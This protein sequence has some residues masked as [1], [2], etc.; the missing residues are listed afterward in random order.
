MAPTATIVLPTQRRP[1]YLQVALASIIPQAR[2]AGVPVL[3]VDDGPSPETRAVAIAHGARYVAHDIP[4]GL[5]AAR[6][7]A[8]DSTGSD[9]LIFVDDDVAVHD[10]WL[11][12]LLDAA[13]QLPDDVGVLTGPIVPVFED[14]ALRMCGRE[15][16]PI[17]FLD[18]GPDDVDAPYAWGANMAVRRS[19]ITR[20]GRF[21]ASRPLYGD[22]AEWQDAFKAAGGRI[23]YI[24]AAGLDH[25]RAGDDSRL[26]S[27][28]TAAYLRGRASRRHDVFKARAPTLRGELRVLAGCAAHTLRFRCAN[29]I[30][31]AAHS[32][33]RVRETWDPTPPTA[34]AG[35][36]DF[37]SG[38]SG[39]VGGL[40]GRG[41]RVRDRAADMRTLPARTAARRHAAANHTRARVLVLGVERPGSLMPAAL[42][43]LHRSAH[44]L[45]IATGPGD[46]GLGKFANLNAQ[47]AGHDL[48][49]A[50]WLLVLDDDVTLPR[51]FL[52][53]LVDQASAAGL[54]LAQ[55][56]HRHHSHASWPVTRR[57]GAGVR[58]TTFVEIGPV[59]L[60]HRDTFASLLPF[61]AQLQM[62]WGL[63]A[64]WAA[65]ARGNGWPI[66][67]VDAVPIGHTVA[68]AGAG[69]S[70]EA[71][72]AEARAFLAHRPYLRRD[73]VRTLDGVR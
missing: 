43:E 50:D 62:G 37:L 9:L 47:L 21:D 63:D 64:H 17:T 55:P 27:L 14:H 54:K 23:R 44:E 29:G 35:V 19:A 42:D 48:Q 12:A 25:R 34:T 45:T 70:R 73:E 31:M 10:G 69:Y 11:A 28:S 18:H 65:L 33:G 66:G 49:R 57:H 4:G 7:T 39:T 36:D 32:L 20:A 13:A 2:A 56:A 6:N 30:V 24:A 5:N 22:E 16:A 41:R 71:A 61:P 72:L 38:V 53:V 8:I 67:V 60:F 59:T 58:R 26:R 51:G 15:G 52:D 3:V 40:R 1:A 46:P 68:P